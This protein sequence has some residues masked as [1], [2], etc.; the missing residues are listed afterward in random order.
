M[1]GRRRKVRGRWDPN[2]VCRTRTLKV[3][4]T[5]TEWH[6]LSLMAIGRGYKSISGYVR[7][8][9]QQDIVSVEDRG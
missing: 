3:R 8:L 7:A 2:Y 9:V 6:Q 1:G 5:P 4:V